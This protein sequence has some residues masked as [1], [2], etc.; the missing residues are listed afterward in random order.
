MLTE[1]GV[2]VA[3]TPAG[4]PPTLKATV[5]LKPLS[6]P[7]LTVEL[8]LPPT[9]TDSEF[10]FADREKSACA[11]MDNITVT[12]CEVLPLVPVMVRV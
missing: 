12:V 5:P 8:V 11:L 10:G 9:V 1:V 3:V 4:A 2:S 7:M 6:A